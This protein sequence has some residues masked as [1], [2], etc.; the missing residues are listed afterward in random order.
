MPALR[1]RATD[2]TRAESVLEQFAIAAGD[3]GQA[4]ADQPGG[5]AA[6]VVVVELRAIRNLVPSEKD[7]CDITAGRA[8]APAIDG[9]QHHGQAL[10]L[11]RCQLA[12]RVPWRATGEPSPKPQQRFHSMRDGQ[13]ERHDGRQGRVPG[14]AWQRQGGAGID[15]RAQQKVASVVGDPLESNLARVQP[16]GGR[17]GWVRHQPH[18]ARVEVRKPQNIGFG[19]VLAG[20]G[21]EIAAPSGLRRGRPPAVIV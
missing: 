20:I 2:Q 3:H 19:G 21:R 11:D 13:I 4:I 7:L 14:D 12:L 17:P 5:A 18:H 9:A 10:A 6:K 8:R 15:R 1:R 16:N